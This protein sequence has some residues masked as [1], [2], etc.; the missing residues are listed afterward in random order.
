MCAPSATA[1]GARGAAPPGP[2]TAIWATRGGLPGDRVT[3]RAKKSDAGDDG[4]PQPTAAS[5]AGQT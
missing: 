1:P 3:D 2:L 4:T 5:T